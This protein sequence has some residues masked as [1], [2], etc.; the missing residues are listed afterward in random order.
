MTQQE[1]QG[2]LNYWQNARMVAVENICA[3]DQ[4]H[5][6]RKYCEVMRVGVFSDVTDLQIWNALEDMRAKQAGAA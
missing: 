5:L 6:A 2:W 4:V 3:Y 1:I